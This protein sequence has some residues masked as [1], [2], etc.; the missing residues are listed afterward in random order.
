MCCLYMRH[1][2]LPHFQQKHH[3]FIKKSKLTL[4]YLPPSLPPK[5]NMET[6]CIFQSPGVL[7]LETWKQKIAPRCPYKRHLPCDFE[8]SR[9][10]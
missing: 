3:L 8:V 9:V 7:D 5:K 4:S 2:Y 1:S 6:W 10:F